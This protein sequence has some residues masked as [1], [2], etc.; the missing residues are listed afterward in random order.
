MDAGDFIKLLI[1]AVVA[2]CGALGTVAKLLLAEKDRQLKESN[3][4]A[5]RWEAA[6]WRRREII[7][8]AVDV[9]HHVAHEHGARRKV[10]RPPRGGERDDP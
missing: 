3:E 10:A 2:M 4:R 8:E 7:D 1:A 6:A 5:D 9:A